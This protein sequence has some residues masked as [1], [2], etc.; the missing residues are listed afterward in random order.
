[1]AFNSSLL[2]LA[3]DGIPAFGR[4]EW[5]AAEGIRSFAGQPLL[6]REHV[7]GVL[8]VFVRVPLGDPEL[9]VL[10]LLA[11]HAAA[12]IASARAFDQIAKLQERLEKENEYLREV[13]TAR[14]WKARRPRPSTPPVAS[15]PRGSSTSIPTTTDR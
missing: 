14:D 15:L 4:P 1:M 6:Y 2:M 11:S 3:N 9:D 12:A 8:G 7:L 10:R 13:V 5:I